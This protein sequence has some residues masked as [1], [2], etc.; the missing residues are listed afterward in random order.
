[1]LYTYRQTDE[2][3]ERRSAELKRNNRNILSYQI[4]A[5]VL[6][7]CDKQC[8]FSFTNRVSKKKIEITKQDF[9]RTYVGLRPCSACFSVSMFLNVC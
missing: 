1:M 7:I 3:T 9:T 2:Q 8:L 5:T 4:S 6:H